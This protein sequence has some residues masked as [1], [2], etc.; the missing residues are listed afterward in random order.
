MAARDIKVD[1]GDRWLAAGHDIAE[2]WRLAVAGLPEVSTRRLRDVWQL[3]RIKAWQCLAELLLFGSTGEEL[4]LLIQVQRWDRRV[5]ARLTCLLRRE[6]RRLL[7]LSESVKALS[8]RLAM[9][10]IARVRRED[11]AQCLL[12][13]GG[14]ADHIDGVEVVD[15]ATSAA[16]PRHNC[17]LRAERRA[18][19]RAIFH[20]VA[21][22]D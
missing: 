20:A 15:V 13:V 6:D 9:L 8:M 21:E 18:C 22:L 16:D 14:R 12:E 2:P 3:G 5:T 11:R 17:K 19:S 4:A 1:L 10:P 7:L